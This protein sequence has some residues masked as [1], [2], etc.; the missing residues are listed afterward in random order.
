MTAGKG[1]EEIGNDCY[2]NHICTGA[3]MLST[4]REQ[5]WD[6]GGQKDIREGYN[7][8]LHPM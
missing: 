3:M 2:F 8:S 1:E 4:G 6:F 5:G 7:R